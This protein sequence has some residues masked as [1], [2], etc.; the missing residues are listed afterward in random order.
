MSMRFF[1]VAFVICATAL[2][3]GGSTTTQFVRFDGG[4]DMEVVAVREDGNWITFTLVGGGE[5]SVPRERVEKTGDAAREGVFFV[6][7]KMTQSRGPESAPPSASALSAAFSSSVSSV[8]ASSCAVGQTPEQRAAIVAAQQA[9]AQRLASEVPEEPLRLALSVPKKVVLDEEFN[10]VVSVSDARLVGAL[11]FRLLFDS[12]ALALQASSDAGFYSGP[13]VMQVAPLG[14]GFSALIVQGSRMPGGD[15][16]TRTV[17]NVRF[18]AFQV[19]ETPLTLSMPYA[20][21]GNGASLPMGANDA[22]VIEVA[23]R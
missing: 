18:K 12:R 8:A 23:V 17:L 2:A 16:G 5:L 11:G 20:N 21:N 7:G 22:V 6:V 4:R 1:L 3:T 9:E 19:G 10:V 13:L 15:S 14:E